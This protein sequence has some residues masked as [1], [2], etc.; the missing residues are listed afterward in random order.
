MPVHETR[1]SSG[2]LRLLGIACGLLI[3]NVYYAQ[4]LTGL[5]TEALGMPRESAGLL[6]TLPLAGYGLGLLTIVPLADLFENKRLVLFLVA[7]EALCV[8]TLSVARSSTAFLASAFAVGATAAAVQ[9]LVPYA[10][11]FAPEAERGKAVG[12]VVSGVMLGIML[13][14]PAASL[15][16]DLFGWRAIFAFSAA[17][18]VALVFGLRAALPSR[19]PAHGLTYPALLSSLGKIFVSTP[20]LR[21]RAF[22]HAFLFAAF[23][24]FWTAL[25]LWLTG[26]DFGLSQSGVAWV[27]LAGVA[28]AIA[29]PFAG[30]LTDHGRSKLGTAIAMLLAMA[31]FLVSDIA[32]ATDKGPGIAAIVAAAIVLDFAVSANLVFG[33]RAIYALGAEQRG[34]INGLFMATFFVGGAIGS[35][36]G[37]WTYTAHGW[38][39]CSIVGASLT[40]MVLLYFATDPASKAAP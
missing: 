6:V 7:L 8:G 28:G 39:G 27:A 24:V 22:Y 4:P 3:A 16:S 2:L 40:V 38:V 1:F 21:R 19:T 11:F 18:M 29:P 23:S 20:L 9:V 35:A 10:T 14:R 17:A 5:I 15:V 31:A 34:R 32:L 25:P 13:A 36:V 37:G 12:K 26:P 30:R 33:Q